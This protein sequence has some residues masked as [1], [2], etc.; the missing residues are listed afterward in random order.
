MALHFADPSP[1]RWPRLARLPSPI[2]IRNAMLPLLCL[3]FR[4]FARTL[5]EN[6]KFIHARAKHAAHVADDLSKHV[7]AAPHL[8]AIQMDRCDGIDAIEDQL[9]PRPSRVRI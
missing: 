3:S 7:D 8:A 6:S 1:I 2:A 4:I 5:Q 9:L